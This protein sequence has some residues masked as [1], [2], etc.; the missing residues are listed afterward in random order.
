VQ[1]LQSAPLHLKSADVDMKTGE[2]SGY[3]STYGGEPDAHGDI[4]APGAYADS[5]KEHQRK[6]T[7]PAMLWHHMSMI[8]IGVWDGFEDTEQGLLAHG[9]LTMEVPQAKSAHAL[10]KDGA[11]ALSVGFRSHIRNTELMENGGRI[12]KKVDLREVSVVA[13]PANINAR[14]TTVKS[15]FDPE[16]PNP[17]QFEKAARDALGLSASQAKRLMSGGWSR[18]ARDESANDPEELAVI[19]EQLQRITKA[20]RGEE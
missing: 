14:I 19:A 9:R 2:F 3:A 4:I 5:L 18:L 12:F 10:M 13:T 16:N 6:G 8:P 17:R 7:R 11:L 20:L 15:A 1:T